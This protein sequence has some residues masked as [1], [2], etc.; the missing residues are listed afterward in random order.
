MAAVVTLD[1]VNAWLAPTK[2]A[3]TA[4]D[5]HVEDIYQVAVFAKLGQ[6][7]DVSGWVSPA[8]T[9][10]LVRKVIAGLTA[11]HEYERRVSEDVVDGDNYADKIRRWSSELLSGIYGNEFDIGQDQDT[12]LATARSLSF[13]P[14]DSQDS[15]PDY[16]RRFL[17]GQGL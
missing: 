4:I 14:T 13:F 8:T 9:P 16:A 5:A 3:L 6:V 17:L 2:Y 10:A 1:D 7:Y 11:A 12:D 15:D